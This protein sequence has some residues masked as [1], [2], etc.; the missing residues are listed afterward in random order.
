MYK[1]GST[2]SMLP[3]SIP[4]S[5]KARGT[6]KTSPRLSLSG[7]RASLL[8]HGFCKFAWA[9]FCQRCGGTGSEALSQSL[10]VLHDLTMASRSSFDPVISVG[11]YPHTVVPGVTLRVPTPHR[12]PVVGERSPGRSPAPRSAPGPQRLPNDVTQ[13]PDEVERILL[14]PPRRQFRPRLHVAVDSCRG[15]SDVLG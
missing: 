6:P 4:L 11:V 8:S 2:D 9:G 3:R 1:F 7:T 13:F 5:Y 12:T 14:D 10:A 15:E